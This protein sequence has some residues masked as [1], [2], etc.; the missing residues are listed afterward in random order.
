MAICAAIQQKAMPEMNTGIV[1]RYY[2]SA[3]QSPALVLG[4]LSRKCHI[5]LDKI[6]RIEIVEVFEKQ[7]SQV[8]LAVGD[9]IPKTLNLE[10]QSYFALGY[11]QKWAELSKLEEK[12]KAD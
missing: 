5:Y 7:L 3:C 11:Y 6:N 1:Q 4:I 9:Q 8:S 2:A 10:E 12:K